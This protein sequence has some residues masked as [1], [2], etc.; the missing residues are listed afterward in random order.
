MRERE[1]EQEQ[2]LEHAKRALK[3]EKGLFEPGGYEI[4]IEIVGAG[5]GQ[6]GG[7]ECSIEREKE[8]EEGRF[9]R[10]VRM[11]WAGLGW[12]LTGLGTAWCTTHI[13]ADNMTRMAI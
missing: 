7:M 3:S 8:G 9:V 12:A 5:R 10:L 13:H 11:N 4:E 2:E 1:Q 6:G